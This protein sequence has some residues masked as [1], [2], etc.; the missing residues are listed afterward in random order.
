MLAQ[1]GGGFN[2]GEPVLWQTS[3]RSD[4]DDRI[5]AMAWSPFMTCPGKAIGWAAIIFGAALAPGVHAQDFPT[6][7]VTL[8][9][10]NAPGGGSDMTARLLAQKLQEI[11]GQPVVLEY[12]PGAGMVVGTNYVA[13]SAPD[14]YTI[15]QVAMPHVINPSVRPDMPF[16]TVK[17][18]SGVTMNTIA[19]LVIAATPSLEAN[20]LAELIALAKK[21]PGKL[22]YATAGAGSSMHLTGELLKIDTGID[23]VHIP[24]KGS[25]PA[26]PDVLAGR[27]QIMI[28][29]LHATMPYIKS[30]KLKPFAIASPR[31]AAVAPNIPT[32]AEYLPG[33]SVLSINGTV[34]PSATPRTIVK[35]INA[36]F[37]A[38]G[39]SPEIRARMAELGLE[40]VGNSPEQFDAF[41]RTELEKWAKVVKVA[42]I[43]AD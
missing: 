3:L 11:W 2:R 25:A 42:G 34:V 20:T 30:G 21:L 41:I 38:A 28:D 18:L 6:R 35:K 9:V 7:R 31:R 36:A 14:G 26:Y 13:K 22:S 27:V 19:H 29:V 33:F 32:V 1:P 23:M 37:V 16:D 5:G 8:V 4:P 17:D 12:K 24:Y 15:G 39:Q 43:T 10:A 40:P